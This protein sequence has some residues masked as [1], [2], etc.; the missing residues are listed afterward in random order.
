MYKVKVVKSSMTFFFLYS[1]QTMILLVVLAVCLIRG[2][3]SKQTL[4]DTLISRVQIELLSINTHPQSLLLFI[5]LV[6]SVWSLLSFSWILV[7][8]IQLFL[9]GICFTQMSTIQVI[10]IF[11]FLNLYIRQV[12]IPLFLI[13][14]TL[15]ILNISHGFAINS[16]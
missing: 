4:M 15:A 11:H 1:V 5:F 8:Q 6:V 13:V 16:Q 3:S 14:K 7:W 10:S 2:S 9:F 12:L